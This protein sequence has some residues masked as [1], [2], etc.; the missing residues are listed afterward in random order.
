MME[1]ESMGVHESV[2][3]R[4]VDVIILGELRKNGPLSGYD[5]VSFIQRKFHASVSSGNVYSVLYALE[6]NGL[7]KGEQNARKRLYTLTD[8]GEKTLMQIVEGS[9]AILPYI[10]SLF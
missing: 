2:V 1:T 10:S 7:V 9:T 6:R 5:I 3:K 8:T 4:F